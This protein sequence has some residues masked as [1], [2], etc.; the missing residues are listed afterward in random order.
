M[1]LLFKIKVNVKSSVILLSL[2]LLLLSGCNQSGKEKRT[3]I[4]DEE[5]IAVVNNKKISLKTF[6]ARLQNFL[7]H[8]NYLIQ[9]RETHLSQIKTI[10]INRMIE[11]E[12][13]IQEA[14]RAGLRVTQKE[15]D[16]SVEAALSP[17]PQAGFNKILT[18]KGI[19]KKEWVEFLKIN[20]LTLKILEHEMKKI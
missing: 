9:S 14:A 7:N 18:Q 8:Y 12:L 16:A 10:V 6:Q 2:L 11:E 15:L 19:N 3:I 1:N 17:Y 5:V 4:S 20:L 13:V